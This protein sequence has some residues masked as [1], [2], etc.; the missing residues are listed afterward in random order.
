MEILCAFAAYALLIRLA[1]RRTP[2]CLGAGLYALSPIFFLNPNAGIG[3][4]P[5]LP[6][7]LL[8]IE[9]CRAPGPRG[10]LAITVSC[11]GAAYA[12]FPEISFLGGI[13]GIFWT[14]ARLSEQPDRQAGLAM[15]AR[16]T[17]GVILGLLLAAPI[18]LPFAEYLQNGD[19]S[20]HE[21]GFI[22]TVLEHRAA[23]LEIFPNLY[24]PLF[25]ILPRM[26]LSHIDITRVPGWAEPPVLTLALAAL[27]RRPA[28][29]S[30]LR[31]AI[32]AFLACAQAREQG[33]APV[34]WL[35]SVLPGLATTDVER[36]IGPAMNLAIFIL[37]A[38]GLDDMLSQPPGRR[39]IVQVLASLAVIIAAL[40]LPDA[41][42]LFRAYFGS[43][44]G[45][46]Q[47]PASLIYLAGC[48]AITAVL[49]W[50]MRG[51]R[52][53]LVAGLVLLGPTAGYI[54]PQLAGYYGGILD[55]APLAFLQ[56]AP[57]NRI[58]SL[59]PAGDNYPS[60]FGIAAI[61]FVALPMPTLWSRYVMAH[62]LTGDTARL[63]PDPDKPLREGDPAA[64]RAVEALGVRYIITPPGAALGGAQLALKPAS[65]NGGVALLPGGATAGAVP[66][67]FASPLS[68]A[69]VTMPV[70]YT[71]TG[72]GAVAAQFCAATAC[73]TGQA[74]IGSAANDGVL[75]LPLTTPLTLPA[76][77][78]LSYR[79]THPD[80]TPFTIW[81]VDGQPAFTLGPPPGP[82]GASLVF[83][84]ASAAI[85]E[86]PHPAPYF[87]A[88]GCTVQFL[89]RQHAAANCA[90]AS[91]LTRQEL[92]FPGWSA[93]VNGAAT[94]IGQNDI[95]ETV[96]LPAGRSDI[97]FSYAPP[98]IRAA[99]AAALAGVGAIVFL[100]AFSRRPRIYI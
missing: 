78:P 90:A 91:R 9:L 58:T 97:R 30:R 66:T 3:A 48:A 95:F 60:A 44:I 70:G 38:Y 53:R 76:G 68:I 7:L 85:F 47:A 15:A 33:L 59:G 29:S 5:F 17:L 37:A 87:S 81:T 45:A 22:H 27:W 52:P 49:L 40:V 75:L 31:L 93:R 13:L 83:R 77:A 55:T 36:F 20:V 39:L 100:L 74:D 99:C 41:H 63:R 82:D 18:L 72:H 11:A 1:L 8:G 23:P 50:A 24:G 67:H 32:A 80:G 21:A 26:T 14:A 19:I 88:P 98:H 96:A 12:G 92:F 54:L 46:S 34:I 4:M 10:W 94:E 84:D 69:M 35:C 62:P 89:T 56:A 51:T 43:D 73:A 42:F 25:Q 28:G 61:T 16:L 86:L 57:A 2:A 65:L 6:L 71:G 79:L 64:F